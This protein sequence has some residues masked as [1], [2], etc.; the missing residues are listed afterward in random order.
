M[1]VFFDAA[2]YRRIALVCSL[3]IISS[4]ALIAC[5][6]EPTST[7]NPTPTPVATTIVATTA[8]ANPVATVTPAPTTAAATATTAAATT[9]AAPTVTPASTTSATLI[10]PRPDIL[11]KDFIGVNNDYKLYED[12]T[13]KDF[14][15]VSKWLRDYAKWFC[16][17]PEENNYGG[18]DG[19]AG[20]GTSPDFFNYNAFYTNIQAA[21]INVLHVAELAPGFANWTGESG[22]YPPVKT[23]GQGQKPEDFLKHAQYLYQIA[24]MYGNNK[25]VPGNTLAF[26]KEKTGQNFIQAIENWN[27]PD[28][29]WKAEGQFTKEQFYNML[30]ADYDGDGGKLAKAGVKQA[31][32][33]MKFVMGGLATTDL[34]Y[35]YGVLA[36]ANQN[37]KKFPADAL[38][39]HEYASDGKTGIS[40]EQAHFGDNMLKAAKWRDTNAPGAGIWV[41]EFGWDTFAKGNEHSYVYASEQ[42]QANWILRGLVLYRAAGV[43]KAF[44]F[45]YNDDEEGNIETYTSSGLVTVKNQKK[46][47]YYYLA[48]MQDMIGDMYL[49]RGINTGQDEVKAY[50]FRNPKGNNGVFTVWKTSSN[51]SKLDNFSLTLPPG[52]SQTC[53]AVVPSKTSL[54]P[55][56]TPLPVNNGKV[57]LSVSETMTFIACDNAGGNAASGSGLGQLQ[58]EPVPG[59]NA[60]LPLAGVNIFEDGPLAQDPDSKISLSALVDE[61]KLVPDDPQAAAPK[62]T[63]YPLTPDSSFAI[64]LLKGYNLGRLDWFNAG[65]EGSFQVLAA[66]PGGY[67]KWQPLTTITNDGNSYG[68][69]KSVALNASNVQYL[70]FVPKGEATLGEL[71][72][73]AQGATPL[74]QQPRKTITGTPGATSNATKGSATAAVPTGPLPSNPVGAPTAGSGQLAAAVPAEGRLAIVAA[75]GDGEVKKLFDGT[76]DNEW[77]VEGKSDFAQFSLALDGVRTVDKIR[78]FV[79]GEGHAPFTTIQYSS[80]GQSWTT[81]KEANGIDTGKNYG[82]N[83]I[84]VGGVKARYLRFIIKNQ[85][86]EKGED[87]YELGYYGEIQV[88]GQ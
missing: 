42:N 88:I 82:W 75:T 30:V 70:R 6:S 62:T 28:G 68:Q 69:W 48:T 76:E 55:T 78:Y 12:G 14:A 67:G 19:T 4:L 32:P 22:D 20:C 8:V 46:P 35:L 18:V 58:T 72:L 16:L 15:R 17:Q 13:E 29:W 77:I 10:K 41:T 11:M 25:N 24:A 43:D 83:E 56:R 57:T 53:T 49:D 60:R 80:D 63:W 65:G 27:E 36:Y 3:L 84:K 44:V 31:D 5:G 38:N 81:F 21:G 64:D 26:P 71:A 50:L 87:I 2:I 33:N 23:Q 66:P 51:G 85:P 39:F 7:A 54:T 9:V 61:Q 79:A 37:G 40:P 86:L 1:I 34:S 52:V 59:A 45:I 47:S 74:V 73:Y